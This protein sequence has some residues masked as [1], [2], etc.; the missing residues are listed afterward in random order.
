MFGDPDRFLISLRDS[1]WIVPG[2]PDQSTLINYLATSNGADA[3]LLT[4]AIVSLYVAQI[5]F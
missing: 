3:T 1:A 5:S 2:R 4:L